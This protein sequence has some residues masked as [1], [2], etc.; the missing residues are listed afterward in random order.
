MPKKNIARDDAN[1]SFQELME[2]LDNSK[3][4]ACLKR[5]LQTAISLEFSTIPPYL[6]ALWSIKEDK[7]EVAESIREIVQE[8]ML[9]MALACNM[10][11][12]IGGQ[13]KINTMVPKYPGPLPGGV[14]S[15][16]I[17]KL[18]GLTKDLLLDFMYIERPLSEFSHDHPE[19][20]L[21]QREEEPHGDTIGAFYEKVKEA[22][23]EID[24]PMD[25]DNQ[26]AGPLAWRVVRTV[27][28]ALYAIDLITEQGEGTGTTPEE[29]EGDLSHFYRFKEVFEE[30]RLVWDSDNNTLRHGEAFPFPD[31]LPMG[32]VPEDGWEADIKSIKDKNERD[33]V[34]FY[35]EQFDIVYTKL[36]DELQA[37]W[38]L[39]GQASLVCAYST[40]F[41]LEKSAKRLMTIKVPRLGDKTFGPR[42]WYHEATGKRNK[43][44]K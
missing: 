22:F 35:L 37:T 11:T 1:P 25:P 8:E 33:T 12:A 19:L 42:F 15:G 41:D 14:H 16:L 44:A 39:G 32:E 3:D 18:S 13:P 9:H 5:V 36:L 2:L 17:A 20:T 27:E 4:V 29:S 7:N 30:V 23:V 10:L 40:M 28:D 31:V 26:I 34:R 6:C 21:D 24:P 38:T 43:D